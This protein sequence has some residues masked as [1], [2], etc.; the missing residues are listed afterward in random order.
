[1]RSVEKSPSP[2]KSKGAF[3]GRSGKQRKSIFQFNLSPEKK[4]TRSTRRR[5]DASNVSETAEEITKAIDM[6][7]DVHEPLP[8]PVAVMMPEIDAQDDYIPPME[9]DY[10][11]P[12]AD[13]DETTEPQSAEP[14]EGP[15][16]KRKRGRPRKSDLSE[17]GPGNDS[18]ISLQ[19][20]I[21]EVH[22]TPRRVEGDEEIHSSP[23][24]HSSGKRR[25]IT[26][27]LSTTVTENDTYTSEP[28]VDLTSPIRP[29]HV[30]SAGQLSATSSRFVRDMS[31]SSASAYSAGPEG[32]VEPEEYQPDIEASPEANRRRKSDGKATTRKA[33]ET[34][35]RQQP[36]KRRTA[37][38]TVRPAKAAA[39]SNS[40]SDGEDANGPTR[41]GPQ[42]IVELRAGTPMEDEGVTM[43]RSGRASIKPLQYW[44]NEQFIWRHGEVEGVVRA[45]E[46][47]QPKRKVIKRKT[48]GRLGSI[49][50]G[51]EEKEED[52]EV[53]A[54]DLLPELWEEELGVINGPVRPWDAEI[55]NGDMSQEV[56]EGNILIVITQDIDNG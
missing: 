32:S 8:A 46:V 25:R 2:T 53:E 34:D 33:R 38:G 19:E 1:M 45:Q 37:K 20:D 29:S 42:S 23:Q 16:I 52:E 12:E 48:D 44:K 36:T 28:V 27:D 7:E 17:D 49:V 35:T 39:P 18:A 22:R 9:D 31:S 30:Q 21:T 43:T 47:E 56:D 40:R 13:Q 14:I 3:G 51:E 10:T 4:S 26:V 55:Q 15:N 54:E 24:K 6:L 5:S 50:E 11:V 41:R